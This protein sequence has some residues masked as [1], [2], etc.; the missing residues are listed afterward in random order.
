MVS[1]HVIVNISYVGSC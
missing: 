1:V